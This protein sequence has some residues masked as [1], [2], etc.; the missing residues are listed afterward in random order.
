[1]N[2]QFA[3]FLVAKNHARW[4]FVGKRV[5]NLTAVRFQQLRDVA[6]LFLELSDRRWGLPGEVCQNDRAFILS[7]F[8]RFFC[9]FQKTRKNA[10][11][12]ENL[13]IIL[14]SGD[15]C[16][17]MRDLETGFLRSDEVYRFSVRFITRWGFTTNGEVLIARWGLWFDDVFCFRWGLTL[18][19]E[20]NLTENR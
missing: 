17:K 16:V 19:S 1:M 12:G 9:F 7:V 4:G 18:K 15:V 3:L 20:E 2:Y 6:F 13:K 10:F 14:R 11:W 8:R 5:E